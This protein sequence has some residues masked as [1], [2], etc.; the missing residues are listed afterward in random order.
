MKGGLTMALVKCKVCGEGVYSGAKVCP[1][2]GVPEPGVTGPCKVTIH[3]EF[4]LSGMGG[5][6]YIDLNGQQ[7]AKLMTNE[8]TAFEVQ[9]GKNVLKA[10]NFMDIRGKEIR[11]EF[12][13]GH[14][15]S[16]SLYYALSGAINMDI[17]DVTKIQ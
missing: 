5:A 16:I 13:E 1:H 2:C 12:L 14:E 11:M 15:Y 8:G 6:I 10:R 7:I 4:R 9:P 3:R 17:T